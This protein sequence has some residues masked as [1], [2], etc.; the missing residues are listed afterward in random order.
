MCGYVSFGAVT[1]AGFFLSWDC[2][3]RSRP[4]RCAAAT[5]GLTSIFSSDVLGVADLSGSLDCGPFRGP[6]SGATTARG[7]KGGTGGGAEVEAP[8]GPSASISSVPSGELGAR[9]VEPE[10]AAP[11][12]T[13]LVATATAEGSPCGT[14]TD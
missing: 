11:L 1:L 12:P 2:D 7:A 5:N 14:V 3:V 8:A 10:G 9:G 4:L 6:F 13:V